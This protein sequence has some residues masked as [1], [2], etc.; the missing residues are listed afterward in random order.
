MEVLFSLLAIF[1]LIVL[2]AT[3]VAAEFAI[4]RIRKTQIDYIADPTD[5]DEYPLSK[6]KTAQL[7]QKMIANI[8]DYISACQV[9]I[10][11]ASLT[12]GAL[13]ESRL[14]KLIQPYISDSLPFGIES[15]SI[16][17]V[18]AIGLITFVHVILGEVVPKNIALLNPED[19]AFKLA[20]FLRF[21]YLLF[22]LPVRIL[23]TCSSLILKAFGIETNFSDY[24]HS[25]DEL[26]MILSSSQAQGVLEEE[27][28][29]LIQNIFE[30]NDIIARNVMVPRSDMVC[31]S[32]DL[33]VEDAA[34]IANRN[35]Y[36]RF[37][38]YKDRV[39]N[40]IGYFTIKDLLK[41]Y[42]AGKTKENVKSIMTDALKVS[43]GMYIIDLLKL[44]QEKKRQIAILIDEFGGVAGLVTAED[45]VEELFGEI[46]DENEKT[47]IE[48]IQKI[49][50]TDYLLDGLLNIEVLNREISTD[51][52]SNHYDTIGGLV[53]G[54]IGTEPKPGDLVE[55]E[56]HSFEVLKVE[57]NRIKQVRLSLKSVESL[58][59][60]ETP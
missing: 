31:V 52:K 51:F 42:Q 49:T 38:V 3:F 54:L 36:S 53:F 47:P 48:P 16:A 44:M 56:G 34:K 57:K 40:I 4:A 17:I 27:E 10:T 5:K 11:V 30:F 50:E 22:K 43:D 26:K 7:L 20:Y 28:E 19:V 35:S 23:N 37:P 8:N 39:D 2:N 46:G 25:E 55:A 13:A 58:Q 60:A 15:H 21:L 12:L 24:A 41:T 6:I 32:S 59:E 1:A 14:E 45:I 9:G 18:L 33:T 29:Q